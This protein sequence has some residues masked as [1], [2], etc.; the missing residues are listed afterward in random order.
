MGVSSSRTGKLKVRGSARIATCLASYKSHKFKEV[1]GVLASFAETQVREADSSSNITTAPKSTDAQPVILRKPP[2]FLRF[3]GL[4]PH[5]LS[6]FKLHDERR[7][8]GSCSC[9]FG[10][11]KGQRVPC[12]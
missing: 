4:W 2:I 3:A 11:H 9:R 1:Y 8:G 7:G 5:N 10:S 12:R 6:Q